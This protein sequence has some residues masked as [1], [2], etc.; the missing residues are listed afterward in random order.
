MRTS[1][2]QRHASHPPAEARALRLPGWSGSSCVLDLVAAPAVLVL[3][4]ECTVAVEH[5]AGV[6][7]GGSAPRAPGA[8]TAEHAL[9][10]EYALYGLAKDMLEY[11]TEHAIERAEARSRI[12]GSTGDSAVG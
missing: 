1:R 6:V 3:A 12:P 4:L 11:H 7:S 8:Q 5:Q 9:M 2:L 10:D